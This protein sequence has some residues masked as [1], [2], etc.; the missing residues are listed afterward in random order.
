MNDGTKLLKFGAL[1]GPN[2]SGK[3]TFLKA[4]D[5]LRDLMLMSP[6]KK[7]DLLD[8]KPFV[9]LPNIEDTTFEIDFYVEQRRMV[10][11]ISYNKMGVNL[12]SLY[13]FPEGRSALV[14]KRSTIPET[15]LSTISFGSSLKVQK[16]DIKSLTG[17]LLHNS[18]VLAAYE[19]TNIEIPLLEVF[20][21]FFKN[22]LM[23][24]IFTRTSFKEWALSK[25]DS[26]SDISKFVS[27]FIS[28]VDFQFKGFTISKD[29]I[30]V[31]PKIL[32]LFKLELPEVEID[33]DN[34]KRVD[35]KLNFQYK[36]ADRS[37]VFDISF[38]EQSDGTQQIFYLAVVLYFL[39]IENKS[40]FIDELEQSLHPDLFKL[41]LSYFIIHSQYSQVL[42][43]SHN[44]QLLSN[45]SYLN[46]E[47]TWLVEK[48]DTGS[49]E[50]YKIADLPSH[51][52]RKSGNLFNAYQS[53][54][55]GAK[56]NLGSPV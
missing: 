26:S 6:S 22:M 20:I 3:S 42:I 39:V 55:L 5:C 38:E 2:A 21:S 11:S 44:Y 25:I 47:N 49:S 12:E 15:K 7:S 8:F 1:F 52:F 16:I 14:F 13:Y 30:D 27:D 23:P 51:I 4:L 54:R 56:P 18:S 24:P 41:W 28:K 9:F 46:H 34:L 31:N 19:R 33:E 37:E 48:N 50:L 53:G 29:E 45:E 10:Y 35:Y 36:V 40:L 17:N 32:Q 43:T